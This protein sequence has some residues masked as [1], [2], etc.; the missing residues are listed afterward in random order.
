MSIP[1]IANGDIDSAEE[2]ARVLREAAVD[3]VMIGR[4]ALGRPW[5]LGQIANSLGELGEVRVP[6]QLGAFIA[7]HVASMHTFYG[8]STAVRMARKHVG[9]YLAAAQR[10]GALT[11]TRAVALRASFNQLNH[12]QAQLDLLYALDEP[13]N[14]R[15]AIEQRSVVA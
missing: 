1:V 8:E 7:A 9:W 11:P 10:A 15:E 3:G 6:R 5:L 12:A 13:E 2:A 4:A 14:W